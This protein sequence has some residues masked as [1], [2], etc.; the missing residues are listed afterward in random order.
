[1]TNTVGELAESRI[2]AHVKS[3][4]SVVGSRLERKRRGWMRP[5]PFDSAGPMP[6]SLALFLYPVVQDANHE[7]G[8]E[9][10]FA[11]RSRSI[12]NKNSS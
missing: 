8:R 9:F 12:P 4:G 6:R 7:A 5:L 10:T 11:C 2:L 1:M 3:G